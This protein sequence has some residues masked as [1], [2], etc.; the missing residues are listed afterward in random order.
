MRFWPG[1][2]VRAVFAC[3]VEMRSLVDA[4]IEDDEFEA[5]EDQAV[6]SRRVLG[7]AEESSPKPL[8]CSLACAQV[9]GFTDASVDQ[10]PFEHIE[11]VRGQLTVAARLLQGDLVQVVSQYSRALAR[12]RSG[13][14]P[15]ATRWSSSSLS[16]P[17]SS[18]MSV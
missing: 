18:S 14:T 3:R 16:S 7:A 11:I 5:I 4:C 13:S 12:N 8:A 10:H 17:S 1:S 9:F 6:S 2:G 15:I